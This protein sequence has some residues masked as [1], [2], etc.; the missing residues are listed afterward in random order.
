MKAPAFWW[1]AEPAST[2]RLLAPLGAVYGRFAARRM[3]RPGIAA[4]MPVICVGNLVAGGAGKTPTALAIGSLALGQGRQPAFLTRGYG[5]RLAGPLVV[6]EERHGSADVG[7]EALLLDRCATTIVSRDRPA[8]AALA[9]S[10]GADLLIMDDGLQN[11]SLRKDFRLAVVDGTTGIGNGLCLPAG[12]LRAP[13]PTQLDRIDALLVIGAGEAGQAVAMHAEA[14]GISVG[15]GR[16]IPDR[17]AAAALVGRRVLAFAGIGRPEKFFETLAGLGAEVAA[18]RA[19]ADHAPLDR[20]TARELLGEARRSG[21]VLATTEKDL[22]RMR[23]RPDLADLAAAVVTVPVR[24]EWRA[25]AA[26]E[27]LLAK[28]A[29]QPLQDRGGA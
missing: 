12:P 13:L 3:A 17:T 4:G 27:T 2:A 24:L 26:L 22:A 8:G 14:R 21:L 7:D 28:R 11:P 16:L 19:F 29:A 6:D 23:G 9:L 1:R 20:R 18:R 25:P 15:R 10:L 5:G